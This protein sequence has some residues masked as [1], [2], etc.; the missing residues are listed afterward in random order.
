[1]TITVDGTDRTVRPAVV[2]RD[3]AVIGLVD[4]AVT[5]TSERGFRAIGLTNAE[6][7][8]AIGCVTPTV[9]VAMVEYLT[10]LLTLV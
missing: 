5:P 3:M 6:R 8:S 7:I 2:A 1:M 4:I 9:D 10:I